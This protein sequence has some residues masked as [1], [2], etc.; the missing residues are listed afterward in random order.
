MFDRLSR[1]LILAL[2][3][4]GAALGVF[5]PESREACG[6]AGGSILGFAIV[7]AARARE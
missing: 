6:V 3:G 1:G 4:G 5:A 7:E 2:T